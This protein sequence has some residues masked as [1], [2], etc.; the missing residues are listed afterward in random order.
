ML[1]RLQ[2]Q[3]PVPVHCNLPWHWGVAK[4][5]SVLPDSEA[6]ED[7]TEEEEDVVDED[8]NKLDDG[9][10]IKHNNNNREDKLYTDYK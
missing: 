6:G 7:T 4:S 5:S 3:L 8:N 2:L 10:D 9:H 1:R